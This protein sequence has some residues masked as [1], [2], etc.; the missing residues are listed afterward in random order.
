M[1]HYE[2]EPMP[3]TR[4][5]RKPSKPLPIL[6][7]PER[8]QPTQ[9]ELATFARYVRCARESDYWLPVFIQYLLFLDNEA[10]ELQVS[11]GDASKALDALLESI[12]A[13]PRKLLRS[14][15]IKTLL[16]SAPGFQPCLGA[17]GLTYP[18]DED[19]QFM[20]LVQMWRREYPEP[21]KKPQMPQGHLG[22]KNEADD[23]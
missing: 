1:Q 17:A 9:D 19:L 3:T 10:T 5:P 18:Y 22:R 14:N 13:D 4:K 16:K 21:P 2:K 11:I 7:L 8:I 20:E 6:E 15:G 23:D 12:K